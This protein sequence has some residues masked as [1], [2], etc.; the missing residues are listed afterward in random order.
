MGYGDDDDRRGLDSIESMEAD[1]G[2]VLDFLE[3]LEQWANG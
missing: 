2:T 1:S 3:A